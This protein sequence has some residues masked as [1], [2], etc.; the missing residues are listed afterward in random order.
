[1]LS[2]QAVWAMLGF[3]TFA[4]LLASG[5]IH[6]AWQARTPPRTVPWDDVNVKEI[7]AT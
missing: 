2:S 6:A 5:G 3:A 7:D 4:V 1:M